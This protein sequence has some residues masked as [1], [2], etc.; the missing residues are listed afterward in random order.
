MNELASV[1][2]TFPD[3]S[4]EALQ[5]SIGL[6]AKAQ[7]PMKTPGVIHPTRGLLEDQYS[8]Y[9]D[10]GIK[11]GMFFIED[12]ILR[13][14]EHKNPIVSLIIN[15]R[16]RQL[17][18][19]TSPQESDDLPG[20]RIRTKDPE[21]TPT[22]A[23]KKEMQEITDW[24]TNC[25]R[26][27]FEDW[28]E[29]EDSFHDVN[30]QMAREYLTIDKVAVELRTDRKGELVDFW[31][32][33]G[34][35]IKRVYPTGYKG[36]RT[37]FDPRAYLSNDD[38]DMKILAARLDLVPEDVKEIRF[39]Q[40]IAGRLTAGFK[41]QDLVYD[42]MQRRVDVRHRGF[43]YSPL[44]QAM[45]VITAFLY[46]MAYNQDNFSFG[47]LPKIALA[48]KQGG[49][50]T[51]QLS[52]MQEEWMA[53]F[54]G[55]KAAFRIPL[56]NSDVQVLD[57]NKSAREMEYQKYLEFTASLI[58]SVFGFDLM[59]AGLKFSSSTN[60]LNEN[61]DSR[62][63]FSKD[64]GLID[65][66]GAHA[67]VW[68]KILK[69]TRWKD[70]YVFEY[71]GLN[72]RDRD[73]EIKQRKDR[74]ESYMTIDE[75]RA[76]ADMPPLPDKKGEVVLNSIYYQHV[77]NMQMQQQS[78]EGGA[79]GEGG[80]EMGGFPSEGE[81]ASAAGQEEGDDMDSIVDEAMDD[82][83]ATMQKALRFIKARTIIH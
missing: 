29:R 54:N 6:L 57:M 52:A 70:K 63:K 51:E 45:S 18:A 74:V 3:I 64:R 24:F 55:T 47:S 16:C 44:E 9:S 59:E 7:D 78:E 22:K 76:E 19:F 31:M 15:T 77:Q 50:S 82:V 72:P 65:L 36:K 35:T 21:Y 66:L 10:R 37:D 81:D 1:T 33:D 40:E 27:D 53:N 20:W 34:A 73:N 69:R 41:R 17:R 68:N 61:Q 83:D 49:F 80:D 75:I 58:G 60:V 48:F 4:Q 79:P 14:I 23:D 2:T 39:V 25:G 43:G 30:I 11:E 56:F 26:T 12:R 46:A 8:L 42:F 28:E 67:N 5:Q 71:T 62:M 38:P 13:Q 32:L